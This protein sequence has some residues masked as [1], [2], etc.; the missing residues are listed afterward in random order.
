[1][2]RLE[3]I[4]QLTSGRSH[5]LSEQCGTI[6]RATGFRGDTR[7]VLEEERNSDKNRKVK[8]G[9]QR[10]RRIAMLDLDDCVLADPCA[11]RQL[12]DRP[13][14]LDSGLPNLCTQQA[15][16]VTDGFW[17]YALPLHFILL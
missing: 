5:P 16:D 2:L 13:F 8:G 3:V 11:L 7:A 14:P 1:V 15:C 4:V 6:L 12:K 10:N 17:V 9:T